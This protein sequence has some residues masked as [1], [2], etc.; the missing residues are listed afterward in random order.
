M[1]SINYYDSYPICLHNRIETRN[2]TVKPCQTLF[3]SDRVVIYGMYLA[4][5]YDV[6]GNQ[7]I[8]N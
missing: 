4:I 6:E 5:R 8:F 2:K 3:C 1:A 7:Y